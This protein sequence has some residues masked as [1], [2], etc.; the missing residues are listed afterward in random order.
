LSNR[1]LLVDTEG[2]PLRALEGD[3]EKMGFHVESVSEGGK[4]LEL[5]E[6]VSF[7]VVVLEAGEPETGGI[8]TLARIKQSRP[9]T[10]VIILTS[11]DSAD[12]ALAGMQAGAFD[13]LLKPCD[14]EALLARIHRAQEKKDI[15][16]RLKDAS[17]KDQERSQR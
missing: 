5:V 16:E 1:I 8:E 4:A 7:D 2:D 10:E 11:C 6:L 3:I 13:Y 12:T 15:V 17:N 9:E 14:P